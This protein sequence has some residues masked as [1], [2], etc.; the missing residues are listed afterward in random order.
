MKEWKNILFKTVDGLQLYL[1]VFVPEDTVNPPLIMW[2]HGGGWNELNRTWSLVMP[3]LEKGCAVASVDYRYCDEAPFPAQ[4]LDLKDAIVYL[5]KH[6]AEY[7]YDGGKIVLSGDSAGAH[8]ACLAGLSEGNS[9][10]EKP[11]EDYSVQ[12]IIDIS[13]PV[14]LGDIV[15]PDAKAGDL[16]SIEKLLDAPC[17]SKAFFS[18][19]ATADPITYIRGKE[20]PVLI[21]QGSEDPIVSAGQARKLRN[22]LEAAGDQVHMYYVPGGLHSMGGELLYAVMSEFLNYYLKGEKTVTEPKVLKE[23]YRKRD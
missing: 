22:A 5:R 23:H 12:A 21:V 17:D 16:G 15:A 18:A 14:S 20:P 1:D 8:L 10:W 19:A 9:A 7:G 13:G 11:G 4:M 2:V 3:M 6:A